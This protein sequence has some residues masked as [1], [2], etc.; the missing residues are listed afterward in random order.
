[1]SMERSY[2]NRAF[3]GYDPDEVNEFILKLE[4]E[5]EEKINALN[6]EIS[7]LTDKINSQS[8][9]A[10]ANGDELSAREAEL[11]EKQ[12]LYDSVCTQV[13]EKILSAEKVAQ[14]IV[15]NAE[16]E[17]ERIKANAVSEAERQSQLI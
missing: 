13:G 10:T 3:K 15:K 7:A 6:N 8:T 12:R 4:S 17:A 2:F 5:H 9:A 1:M 14:E 16:A 11:E